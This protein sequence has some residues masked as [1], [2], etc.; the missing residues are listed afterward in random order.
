MNF[1]RTPY[2]VLIGETYLSPCQALDLLQWLGEQ[3]DAL[4]RVEPDVEVAEPAR[5]GEAEDDER[6]AD[7]DQQPL[8]P[9]TARTRPIV[10][11]GGHL[12]GRA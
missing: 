4:Q 6:D 5:A 7:A 9:R 3:R 10:G 12:G 8:V 11:G 1:E 2:G